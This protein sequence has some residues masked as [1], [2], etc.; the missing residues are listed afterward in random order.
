MTQQFSLNFYLLKTPHDQY[1]ADIQHNG[2]IYS[3]IS[4]RKACIILGMEYNS[5]ES[6]ESCFLVCMAVLQ[7][8]DK[9]IISAKGRN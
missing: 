5:W 1:R 9:K 3:N 6:L 2:E 4:L 8:S 7:S